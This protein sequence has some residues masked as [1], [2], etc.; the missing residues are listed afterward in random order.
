MWAGRA[1]VL[2]PGEVSVLA[3]LAVDDGW[4]AVV[5]IAARHGICTRTVRRRRD[6]AVA[7]LQAARPQYLR[8]LAAPTADPPV[9]P[10]LYCAPPAGAPV[11]RRRLRLGTEPSGG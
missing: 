7:A 11:G 10:S 8:E 4:G 2:E 6:R 5:R 3:A 1:A 9:K